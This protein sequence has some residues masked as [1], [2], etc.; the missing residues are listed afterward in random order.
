[1]SKNNNKLINVLSLFT[2]RGYAL[3]L[4]QPCIIVNLRVLQNTNFKSNIVSFDKILKE[5]QP[6]Y[7]SLNKEIGTDIE[8]VEKILI[9]FKQIS[10]NSKIPILSSN[11]IIVQ[12][13]GS[14]ML[15]IPIIGHDEMALQ[16]LF[17][18]LVELLNTNS[19]NH[20]NKYTSLVNSLFSVSPKGLN[21]SKLLKVALEN[22]IPWKHKYGNIFQFG[23]G[24]KSRLL[25]STF[26]DRT[27]SISIKIAQ[28]KLATK[29]L[30]SSVGLPVS[31]S[32]TVRSKAEA[33]KMAQQLKYPVVIKP[34][35]LDG[36]KGVNAGLKTTESVELAYDIASKLSQNI[37][38]EK[39]FEGND[40]R[41]H[42]LNG[43]FYYA[44][45]RYGA[46]VKGDGIHTVSQLVDILN[47]QRKAKQSNGEF[48][49]VNISI[50]EMTLDL[51]K[52]QKLQTSSIPKINKVVNIKRTTNVSTGGKSVVIEDLSN[53]HEDNVELAIKAVATLRLDIAAV[54]LMIPDISKSWMEVGAIIT[55]INSRPQF[56]LDK[57]YKYFL[58]KLIPDQGR[59][60]TII[61]LGSDNENL[62]K[63]IYSQ[64]KN[65]NINLGIST[66][67]KLFKNDKIS[68]NQSPFSA[69]SGGLALCSDTSIDAIITFVENVDMLK[70]GLAV[71]KFDLLVVLNSTNSFNNRTNLNTYL[72]ELSNSC[73][74]NI[75]CEEETKIDDIYRSKP[76]IRSLQEIGEEILLTLAR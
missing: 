19:D 48:T 73:N 70:Q 30:L 76:L 46:S 39:H 12:K 2:I 75:I 44:T 28:N 67:N 25:D 6:N 42:I 63:S 69:Y 34:I 49:Y 59:I 53:I 66:N 64:I 52:E 3:N 60:P 55:E 50:D 68:S 43:E 32:Y 10:F 45:Q 16:S 22:K 51:L 29:N 11:E 23:W 62:R 26:S 21:T 4:N 58:N 33:L 72:Q 15:I 47:T 9:A 20:K 41:L 74:A 17:L 8:I 56:G 54:D 38:V 7:L 40:Y 14:L 61:I 65:N 13:D 24:R 18:W 36:G 71:D 1:M 57:Q 35:D 5:L 31:N 37:I 27:S